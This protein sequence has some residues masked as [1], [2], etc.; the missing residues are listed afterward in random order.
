MIGWNDRYNWTREQVERTVIARLERDG[1]NHVSLDV[2]HSSAS[3]IYDII[4]W[5][6]E[7]GYHATENERNETVRIWK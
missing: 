6:E 7:M 2:E 1:D 3:N 5:A 4:R